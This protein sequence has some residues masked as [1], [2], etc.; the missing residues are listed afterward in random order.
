MDNGSAI[1]I[2]MLI[3]GSCNRK[4]YFTRSLKNNLEEKKH[5]KK[6]YGFEW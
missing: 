1:V 2:H 4:G 6:N 3:E 5:V